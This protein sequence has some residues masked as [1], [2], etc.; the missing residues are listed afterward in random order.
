MND[1]AESASWLQLSVLE[2]L[3]RWPASAQLFI[4][5]RMACV[6]CAFSRFDRVGEALEVHALNPGEFLE[7]L[8]AVV[9]SQD[10]LSADHAEGGLS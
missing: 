7:G 2:V 8:R 5:R 1:S 4:R 9:R 10:Q 3:N 6:G